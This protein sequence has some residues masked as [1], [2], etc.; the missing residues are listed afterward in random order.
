MKSSGK[1]FVEQDFVPE[2]FGDKGRRYGV[3]NVSVLQNVPLQILAVVQYAQ[4]L[5]D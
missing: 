4:N 3:A 5:Y 2:D 1:L